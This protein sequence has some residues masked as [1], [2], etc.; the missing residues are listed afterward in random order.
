MLIT[1]LPLYSE[2][3]A[4]RHHVKPGITGWAQVNGRNAI[5]WKTKFELDVFYVENLNFKLDVA[6]LIKTVEKVF[7]REGISSASSKTMD[8]FNGNYL[9]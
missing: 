7:K 8:A 4:C 6:I 9:T 3:Q 1:Y 5:D 2:E